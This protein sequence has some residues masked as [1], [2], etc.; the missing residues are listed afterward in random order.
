[1]LLYFKIILS[2]YASNFLHRLGVSYSSHILS[3]RS[4]SLSTALLVALAWVLGACSQYST[5]PSS[6]L[7]HNTTA[8]FNAYLQAY[9]RMEEAEKALFQSRKED[10]GQLLPILIPVDSLSAMQVASDMDAVLKKASLVVERHQNSKWVDDAYVLIGRVRLHKQDFLNAIETFKYINTQSDN[11]DARHAAIVWLMRAYVE[12]QDFPSALRVSEYLREQSLNKQNSRDF[13]LTKAYLHQLQGE[14]K[15]SVGILEQAFGLLPK[16]QEKA[17][18]HFAAAQMYELLNQSDRAA[19][20]YNL[21]RKNNPNYDLNFYASLNSSLNSTGGSSQATFGRMLKDGKN[22]EL[23][24]KIYYAMAQR[25]VQQKN[26]PTAIQHLKASAAV[27]QNNTTQLSQTYRKLAEIHYGQFQQY[28]LA[29]AYYDSTVATMPPSANDYQEIL[30]RKEFLDDFVKQITTIRTEDSLQRLAQMNPTALDKYFDKILADQAR[31]EQEE[32]ERA[33][34]LAAQGGALAQNNN[35]G[36]GNPNEAWYFYNPTLVAQGKIQFSQRWGNRKLEDNW[37][38]SA[39]ETAVSLDAP[40]AVGDSSRAPSLNARNN[41]KATTAFNPAMFKAKKEEMMA[42]IPFT[43][44][45][46]GESKKRQ[47][48]AYFQLGKIYK[49]SLN[50]PQNANDTFEK[51]L[52][53]FPKTTHE[54]EALYLLCLLTE[55]KPKYT[56]WKAQLLNKHPDSYFARLI[57]RGAVAVTA[58]DE[59]EAQRLYATAYALYGSGGYSD[60]LVAVENGFRNFPNNKIEDKFALLKAMLVAKTQQAAAYI[61]ALQNFIRDYP[62]SPLL[63]RAQDMLTAAEQLATKQ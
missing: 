54:A 12:Q 22:K 31:K 28:E 40:V 1:M 45:A 21:V 46:L 6:R 47:E 33:L 20:H 57:N 9:A 17:R 52:T 10:F 48:E 51:L 42:K 24:D 41:T 58:G 63:D 60:A 14:Y 59:A 16:S 56:D 34:R 36:F 43:E 19:Y 18:V 49:L 3:G 27:G 4:R 35:V 11:P 29:K 44:A 55:G 62:N 8:K 32:M 38:R 37:R 25:E 26:Y 23:Q 2:Y 53:L 7:Y 50:E 5:A 61:Q 13:Y 30:K 15:V 39:K